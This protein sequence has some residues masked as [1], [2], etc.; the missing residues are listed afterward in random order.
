MEVEGQVAAS[1]D[2]LMRLKDPSLIG[3]LKTFNNSNQTLSGL[4]G[5][6]V[7]CLAFSIP[8]WVLNG[9]R[10]VH[11]SGTPADYFGACLGMVIFLIMDLYLLRAYF[12][13][14]AVIG[15]NGRLPDESKVYL[16]A[17]Q[18]GTFAVLNAMACIRML[19][20][21]AAGKCSGKS[22]VENWDCN[23]VAASHSIPLEY[24]V[25]AMLIPIVYSTTVRGA[26]F[27]STMFLWC[28]TLGSLVVS[29]LLAR[30]T[31]AIFF[32]VVY[33]P[34]SLYILVESRRQ[35][36]CLFFTHHMLQETLRERE[37]AVDAANALEMR[38]MIA[39]VAHD[40]KTVSSPSI[41]VFDIFPNC[42]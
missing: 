13:Q 38:H 11:F 40:L 1:V 33:V 18:F 35:N 24:A 12:Q 8:V 29:L 16:Q 15:R 4:L 25:M 14:K 26:H 22:W 7:L 27:R 10:F 2:F 20:K 21:S 36:Y 30:A 42:S 9:L 32:V 5:L 6:V 19:I 28:M 37:K 39:N 34:F 17:V 23:A 41:S 3:P 31:E